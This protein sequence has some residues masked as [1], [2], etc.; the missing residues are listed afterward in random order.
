P[1]KMADQTIKIDIT[2][3]HCANCA[4]TIERRL[5]ELKGIKSVLINFS[6]STGIIAFDDHSLNKGRIFKRLKDA[7]FTARE[8]L[9]LNQTSQTSYQI[10]WLVLSIV[11]SMVMMAMMHLSLPDTLHAY[12]PYILM[13]IATAII[14]GPG[15][16]FLVSAYKS[17][18]NLSANMDVL[19]S[20]GILSSYV[21]S[22]L[23]LFHVFSGSHHAFFETSVM[24][25][26]FIRIGKSLE[27][28]AKGRASLALQKLIKLQAD[29]A[30][31]LTADGKES[32]VNASSLGVGDVVIV[33][34]GEAIPADGIVMEGASSVDESLVTGEAVPVV[35]QK[36]DGVVGATINKTGVLT[37]QTTKVGEETVLSQIINLVEESLMDKA[38]IQ[39]FADRVSN[40]FVP[41][42]VGISIVT[43][44]CWYFVFYGLAGEPPFVWA[45]KMA[46]AVLVIA[47]PCAMGLATPTALMVGSGVGL[48]N[49]ILIKRAGIL[50]KIAGVHVFIMDKTGTITEG[51]PVVTDRVCSRNTNE[52]ELLALA[53][54]GCASS[55][56]P[57]AQSVALKAKEEGIAW[58]T[59]EDFHE[60]AGSGIACRY[61]GKELLIGNEG[62]LTSHGIAVDDAQTN[63]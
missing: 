39:R 58:D 14:L 60:A 52:S 61:K 50:E 4:V 49:S 32:L 22:A 3:M 59:V 55:N 9:Q 57:L 17:I 47:C 10:G 26:A 7:G 1:H 56:H 35:K 6:R 19:V 11:A 24:L 42:V 16:D 15:R 54:A 30:R 25:I 36:G 46:V 62:L 2:G 31:V 29:K 44:I 12:Q 40:V 20:I 34:A 33:R 38:P 28:R 5:K 21:Y 45:L 48:E 41:I 23:A 18:K 13:A 8:R 37:I 63:A 43:F 53:A 51:R 27:E